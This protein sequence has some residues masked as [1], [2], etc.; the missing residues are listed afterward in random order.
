MGDQ[1]FEDLSG[2]GAEAEDHKRGSFVLT[3]GVGHR[4]LALW[5]EDVSEWMLPSGQ[6]AAKRNHA[7]QVLGFRIAATPVPMLAVRA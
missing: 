6:K 3:R 1:R 7:R 5:E 2:A 4:A